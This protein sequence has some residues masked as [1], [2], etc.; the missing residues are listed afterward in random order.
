MNLKIKIGDQIFNV[1]IGSLKDRPI[2]VEVDGDR[3]EVWPEPDFAHPVSPPQGLNTGSHPGN[4][5][6][7]PSIL[8]ISDS[9]E[10]IIQNGIDQSKKRN[11][12]IR[13]PIPGVITALNVIPGSEVSVGQELLKLEAMKMNNSIHSNYAGKISA[14]HVSIG[15]IVKLNELLLEFD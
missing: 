9:D 12:S 15:Q 10:S 11:K 5:I 6:L 3:F 1:S 8:N 13:A 4:R 7:Q 14:V 2:Q